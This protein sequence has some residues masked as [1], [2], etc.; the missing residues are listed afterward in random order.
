MPNPA[1]MKRLVFAA[2]VLSVLLVRAQ[3]RHDEGNRENRGAQPSREARPGESPRQEPPRFQP[4]P[5]GRNPH[6]P[7]ARPPPVRTLQPRVVAP[8]HAEWKHWAHPVFRRPIYYWN[9][10]VVRTV[11]CVAEDSYG[12]QY[13]VT[14]SITPGFQ[15]Q[16]MTGVE[17]DALDRCY[18]ESGQDPSCMLVGC[19][20]G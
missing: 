20:H 16:D 8:G 7:A 17:D 11:T 6:G 19:S 18:A 14:E 15:L 10:A 1:R 9:W 5:P 2:V 12:D 4:H 3:E 13:P